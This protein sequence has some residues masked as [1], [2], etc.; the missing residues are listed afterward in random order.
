MFTML[1]KVSYKVAWADWYS[2]TGRVMF[3]RLV[4]G[5]DDLHGQH[6]C[7]RAGSQE[8]FPANSK[9]ARQHPSSGPSVAIALQGFRSG[10][11][12]RHRSKRG[13]D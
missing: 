13:H 3:L 10:G 5:V 9:P 8:I 2:S 4:A 6:P 1:R 7:H 12:T 11:L